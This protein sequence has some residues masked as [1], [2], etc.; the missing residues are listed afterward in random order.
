M[1]I[2]PIKLLHNEAHTAAIEFQEQCFFPQTLESDTQFENI[3]MHEI[4]KSIFLM[5]FAA[6]KTKTKNFKMK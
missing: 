1:S 6:E 3:K 5:L 2:Y 4:W